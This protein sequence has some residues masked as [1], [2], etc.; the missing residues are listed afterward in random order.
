MHHVLEDKFYNRVV[1]V[2]RVSHFKMQ[3]SV[4]FCS[5]ALTSYHRLDGLNNTF[6]L[7]HFWRLE[8]QDHSTWR[9]L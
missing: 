8:F 9:G 5:A 1:T 6:I 7:P 4:L 3:I 2:E